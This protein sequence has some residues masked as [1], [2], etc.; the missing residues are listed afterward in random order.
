MGNFI[1]DLQ[2]TQINYTVGYAIVS[3]LSLALLIPLANDP[4]L[5]NYILVLYA[6]PL[7]LLLT[8]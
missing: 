6:A 8:D 2:G 3:T 5:D 7:L 4:L 1:I